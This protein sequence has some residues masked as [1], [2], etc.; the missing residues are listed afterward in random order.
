MDWILGHWYSIFRSSPVAVNINKSCRACKTSQGIIA[1]FPHEI[2]NSTTKISAQFV[3]ITYALLLQE[4]WCL[5]VLLSYFFCISN[6][7]VRAN[8]AL[9]GLSAVLWEPW[10]RHKCNHLIH[11]L[12]IMQWNC[13]LCGICGSQLISN[14]LGLYIYTVQLT[15][16]M[17]WSVWYLLI[18]WRKRNTQQ[19]NITSS[20]WVYNMV[21]SKKGQVWFLICTRTL[22][23]FYE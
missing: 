12:A 4:S 9:V 19:G 20:F 16:N 11:C 13:E 10:S 23:I 3:A 1:Y 14:E 17:I 8:H 5:Q 18:K 22:S 7:F 15:N 2:F 21:L 6:S